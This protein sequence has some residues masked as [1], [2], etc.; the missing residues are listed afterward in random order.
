[1]TQTPPQV[2]DELF[3]R[4]LDQLGPPAMVEL[5][6]SVG[7]A[8]MSTRSNSTMGIESQGFSQACKVPLAE[9]S[10]GYAASA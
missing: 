2:T 7:F 1:M 4:L 10:I 3:A 8:N 6:A 5:T 9:R